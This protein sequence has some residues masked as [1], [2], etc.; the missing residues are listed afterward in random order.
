MR[1]HFIVTHSVSKYGFLWGFFLANWLIPIGLQ[2][3]YC[4]EISF[5]SLV[6][7]NFTN[8]FRA[9]FQAQLKMGI[10]HFMPLQKA[11]YSKKFSS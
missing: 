8:Y 3:D 10:T 2:W 5:I 9:I 11:L 6:K 7:M 1:S 4:N